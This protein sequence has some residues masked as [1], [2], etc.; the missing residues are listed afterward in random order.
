MLQRSRALRDPVT[1]TLDGEPIAAERGEPIAL[2]LLARDKTILARSPKLHRPRG[3]SCLRGGCDGCLARV[4]GVPNVMT[5]LRPARG[6]EAIVSQNVVGSRKADLLRVTDWFFAQGID[7][8][9]LMAGIPGL[10]EVMVTFARKVAG[11]G[12][13][14]GEA[15]PQKPARRVEVDVAVVGG[16]IAGLAAAS[17]LAAGK[18]RVILVD[19]GL[20]LGGSLLGAPERLGRALRAHPLGGVEIALESVAAGDYFG[21]LLIA[22]GDGALVV[23]PRATIFATGAHDGV[24]LVPGN[25]LPG[26]FSARA[27]CRILH[28]GIDPDGPVAIVGQGF[29]ADEAAAALGKREAIRLA[30]TDVVAVHG[31]AGVKTLEVREG[32]KTRKRA[33]AAVALAL[34]GAPAFE[35]P[36]QAG[37]ETRAD[38]ATGYPVVIRERGRAGASI[39]AVGECTG[40]PFD[41]D[42]I[43]AEAQAA[44]DDVIAFL[45]S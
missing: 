25:D 27:F 43:A 17:R 45:A 16:G 20:S 41:P 10:N 6:G 9:H 18:K 44:A 13:L 28:A 1:I 33:V 8:H 40:K 26:I 11:L 31:T 38:P 14:P 37:A 2:S 19:D 4:D 22:T 35:L 42:A 29:W 24:L 34:P 3:P 7:H 30:E 39:W 36:A 23:R 5:C 12:R 21:D 15:T 32:K